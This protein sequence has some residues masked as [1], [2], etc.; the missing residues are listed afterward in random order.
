M[1]KTFSFLLIGS[2]FLN[3]CIQSNDKRVWNKLPQVTSL[4]TLTKTDFTPTLESEIDTNKNTIYATS[5]LYAW[6]AIKSEIK[7]SII[8][9]DKNSVEFKELNNSRSFVNTLNKG[10]YEIDAKVNGDSISSYA[11]FNKTLPFPL[12]LQKT[13]SPIS[14][15]KQKVAAFGM[16]HYEEEIVRMAEVIYY[17]DDNHFI[18]K[19]HPKEEEHKLILAMGIQGLTSFKEV[20]TAIDSLINVGEKEISNPKLT[21]KYY[22]NEDDVFEIPV[23]KFNLEKH[24]NKIEKQLFATRRQQYH[25][26]TAYQRTGF[27]LN[28]EGAVIESEAVMTAVTDTAEVEIKRRP[29]RLIFDKPFFILAKREGSKNPYF[30][31]RIANVELLIKD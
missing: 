5:L 6:D 27:I 18:L 13:D 29:K 1:F 2:L 21:W 12:K 31:M 30:M 9:N 16:D 24:Y 23:I 28:E 14:F 11:F 26:A 20:L 25:I 10:E 7:D 3:A 17:K 22:L 15:T 8:L 19:L 4:T